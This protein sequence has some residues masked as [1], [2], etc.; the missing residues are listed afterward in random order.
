MFERL[1]FLVGTT[2]LA[3]LTLLVAETIFHG[4]T[5]VQRYR[6]KIAESVLYGL[7]SFLTIRFG[8]EIVPGVIVDFRGGVIGLALLTGGWSIGSVAVVAALLTRWTLGGA[9]MIPGLF[10][11]CADFL[12]VALWLRFFRGGWG[13]D[14][15]PIRLLAEVGVLVGVSEAFSLAAVDFGGMSRDNVVFNAG[16]LFLVQL[17]GTLSAGTAFRIRSSRTR[18]L[19]QLRESE[20]RFRNL[21]EKSP[22]MI[23]RFSTTRGAIY[24]SPQVETMLGYSVESI[25]QNP[26]GWKAKVHPDDLER[27]LEQVKQAGPD[28]SFEVEYRFRDSAGNWRWLRDRSIGISECGSE[29]IIDGIITDITALRQQQK[30]FREMFNLAPEL[31]CEVD[32]AGHLLQ[33]NP[34]WEKQLGYAASELLGRTVFEFIHPQDVEATRRM[35]DEINFGRRVQGFINRYQCK[36]GGYRHIEWTATRMPDTNHRLGIGRD[37]TERLLAEAEIRAAH[38]RMKYLIDNIPD[39]LWLK[40]SDGRYLAVNEAWK[41]AMRLESREVVGKTARELFPKELAERFE[42]EDRG[43]MKSGTP[44]QMIEMVTTSLGETEQYE[45]WKRAIRIGSDEMLGTVGCARNITVRLQ[46]EAK[47]AK[48]KLLADLASDIILF[49]NPQ[50]GRIVEANTSALTSYGYDR[51]QLLSLSVFDLRV[52]SPEKVQEQLAAAGRVSS[53]FEFDHR[54][55][56]G[57]TFPVEVQ[58]QPG[59]IDGEKLLVSVIRDI[60]DR[61]RFEE[62]LRRLNAELE[63]RV[64]L[65]TREALEL[66]QN[67]PCGYHA[68]NSSGIVEQMNARE[69]SWLG[70]S[71][72]EVIGRMAFANLLSTE[73]AIVFQDIFP[74]FVESGQT[75]TAQWRMRRKDGS[76]FPVFVT[77]QAIR[78]TEGRFIRTQTNLIDITER[79]Q[80]EEDLRKARDAAES[81]SRSKTAFLTNISHELRTPLNAIIGFSEILQ[82]DHNLAQKS[83]DHLRTISRSG[84][85]LIEIIGDVLEMARIEAGNVA[86]R[87]IRFE[88]ESVLDDLKQFFLESIRSKGLEFKV[89][90]TPGSPGPLLGDVTKVRQVLINLVGNAVKFTT[91][92]TISVRI[93]WKEN[94]D[95]NC[96]IQGEVADTGAGIQQEDIVHLF[97]PFYQTELG[98]S[99]KGGTGLGLRITREY[100]QRMGGEISVSSVPG[101]G[102]CFRFQFPLKFASSAVPSASSAQNS[103]L[104][105]GAEIPARGARVLVVDDQP[106]NRRLLLNI[107]ESLGYVVDEAV[108]GLDSIEKITREVPDFILMDLQMPRMDGCQAIREI[109][110]LKG[111]GVFIIAISAGVISEK[112]QAAREAGADACLGKPFKNEELLKLMVRVSETLKPN[113]QLAGLKRSMAPSD[114][115]LKEHVHQL[116]SGSIQGLIS[117]AQNAEYRKLT[118]LV[119]EIRELD[120]DLASA[121][122]SRVEAFDYESVLQ[123]LNPTDN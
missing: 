118:A 71:E 47:L 2:S 15:L 12:L 103:G 19:G 33:I 1:V 24:C 80:I 82:K 46:L 72:S 7:V 74:R 93:E 64:E 42:E 21:V 34:A 3:I 115:I 54:R 40:D 85:H 58:V 48:Y 55:R 65:K 4:S 105:S 121:L 66:Y 44:I 108:D 120:P 62:E 94:A 5:L 117:A 13:R 59:Y 17:V 27:K 77:V 86:L 10:G 43:M 69:L 60:T 109:R 56:D 101:Q 113:A 73:D 8:L 81:A 6:R 32:Y 23:Y 75:T 84:Q 49:I 96:Q 50:T 57:S 98:Y 92:G 30:L 89:E 122:S 111:N 53:R 16:I 97:K 123:L 99:A 76:T 83:R 110:R 63:R 28:K 88:M 22:D 67:A 31:I 51:Q 11:I 68:V 107:L 29:T 79:E 18:I 87:S 25:V 104:V 61:R 9:G 26:F 41:R 35:G 38:E 106:D 112:F 70:Y 39:P 14:N 95:G 119:D 116:P 52:D 78:D 100:L 102:S 114:S 90:L 36:G 20:E 45:A 37:V 91:S